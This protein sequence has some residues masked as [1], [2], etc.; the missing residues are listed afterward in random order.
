VGQEAIRATFGY[1]ASCPD[2][3]RRWAR[4]F[5]LGTFAAGDYPLSIQLAVNGPTPATCS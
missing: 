2:T 5:D 4:S 3:M 1:Q